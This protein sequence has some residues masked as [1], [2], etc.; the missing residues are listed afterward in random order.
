MDDHYASGHQV[1]HSVSDD[2]RTMPQMP[3]YTCDLSGVCYRTNGLLVRH[4]ETHTMSN[5]HEENERGEKKR[6]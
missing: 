3:N 4:M 6:R 2:Q 1:E 5:I